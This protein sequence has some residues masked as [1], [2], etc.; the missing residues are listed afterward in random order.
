M[1]KHRL[2]AHRGDNTNYPEN[3]YP[4]IKAALEMGALYIEFD[5]QMNTDGTLMV[6]HDSD[7]IR[8]ANLNQSIFDVTDEQISSI[9]IHEPDR[10]KNQHY[11]TPL[12]TLSET[13]ELIEQ[14][15]SAT[16]FVEIKEESLNRFG[17]ENVMD[18]LVDNLKNKKSN[19]VIISFSYEAI[20]YA[21]KKVNSDKSKTTNQ[22]LQT[23]W[24]FERYNSENHQRALNL[25]PQYL[26]CNYK[27]IL[28]D[29]VLS[30][31]KGP[32]KWAVYTIND[33]EIA[34]RI[35]K[36]NIDLVETNDISLLMNA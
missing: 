20:E 5:V 2:V 33:I 24:V 29:S 22:N 36:K 8:T 28:N 1:N 32:W 25:Q 21:Q 7:L 13:M 15:P 12:S 14:F 10:F 26:F 30:P 31:W 17:L 18:I 6:L 34:K 35:L 19:I 16:T 9:S 27:E 23:G 4:G 11:P 3:S